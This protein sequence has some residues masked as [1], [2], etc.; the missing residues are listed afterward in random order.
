MS[1]MRKAMVMD[2]IWYR[3]AFQMRGSTHAHSVL[4]LKFGLVRLN[5]VSL[6]YA[7]RKDSEMR[8]LRTTFHGMSLEEKEKFVMALQKDERI[9]DKYT[10][11]VFCH[12][13]FARNK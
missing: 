3:Y 2:W 5:L 6:V 4:K 7:D 13:N 8:N 10:G 12:Q 11:N 1:L 9:R